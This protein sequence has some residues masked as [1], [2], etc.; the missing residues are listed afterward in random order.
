[1]RISR[2]EPAKL[3]IS[4][5][6]DPRLSGTEKA[7]KYGYNEHHFQA[8]ARGIESFEAHLGQ[9]FGPGWQT[10]KLQQV[11]FVEHDQRVGIVGLE[12]GSNLIIAA[13][14]LAPDIL[15]RR[16]VPYAAHEYAHALLL[17]RQVFRQS[18]STGE[19]RRASVKFQRPGS[20]DLEQ[21]A[22]LQLTTIFIAALENGLANPFVSGLQSDRLKAGSTF[23][24]FMEQT[25]D[26]DLADFYD[27]RITLYCGELITERVTDLIMPRTSQNQHLVREI[28]EENLRDFEALAKLDETACL[29]HAILGR[30]LAEKTGNGDL[31]HYLARRKFT[32][33]PYK[34]LCEALAELWDKI[35][36]RKR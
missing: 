34:E 9:L 29:P 31:L 8:L 21:L 4:Q 16:L 23:R 13:D 32:G 20:L 19:L 5:P 3:T 33:S 7:Q 14:R 25:G 26:V 22:D 36:L 1:M 30:V 28:L 24:W 12:F 2:T 11:R 18:L 6:L 10:V 15:L 17:N 35:G 27:D